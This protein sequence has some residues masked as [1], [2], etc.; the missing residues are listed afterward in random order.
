ML[1]NLQA[2]TTAPLLVTLFSSCSLPTLPLKLMF[3]I[4][5]RNAEETNP[6]KILSVLDSSDVII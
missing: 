1:L 6:L 5:A 2:H 3:E 4:D